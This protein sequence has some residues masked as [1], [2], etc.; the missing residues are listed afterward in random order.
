MVKL[1]KSVLRLRLE[2][3]HILSG[4]LFD[5]FQDIIIHLEN[6]T[7]IVTGKLKDFTILSY[8]DTKTTED[9]DDVFYFYVIEPQKGGL[10]RTVGRG[11]AKLRTMKISKKSLLARG[12]SET[13]IKE[14]T[15]VGC[16]FKKEDEL[17]LLSPGC[18][19]TLAQKIQGGNIMYKPS[20]ERDM[21]M[22]KAFADDDSKLYFLV[23][24][25]NGCKKI[26]ASFTKRYRALSQNTIVEVVDELYN[27]KLF[28]ACEIK[29]WMVS[30]SETI[31]SLMFPDL[32][33]GA[34]TPGIM[35]QTSDTG[36]S[37]F[38]VISLMYVKTGISKHQCLMLEE[39]TIPHRAGYENCLRDV[40][41][42]CR[43][44]YKKF[45]TGIEDMKKSAAASTQFFDVC[46]LELRKSCIKKITDYVEKS[47]AATS[48]YDQYSG[49]IKGV[50]VLDLGKSNTTKVLK[51]LG[52]I[53][54]R[55]G[56]E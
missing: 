15:M 51:C 33:E 39:T 55:I 50:D 48:L 54:L 17:L 56:G 30:N 34:F 29:N 53:P 3:T 40:V 7:E 36:K 44:V 24:T 49:V 52:E 20:C 22:G 11:E 23:R 18:F 45:L 1:A 13:L 8:I 2:D 9:G 25:V 37:S 41:L 42:Q 4:T 5:E 27:D 28:G 46:S 32:T 21:L 19:L 38:K 16:L 12:I 14:M 31:I 6:S 43:E 35:F 26:F 10:L 47:S